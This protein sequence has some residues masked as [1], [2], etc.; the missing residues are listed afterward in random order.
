MLESLQFQL[1]YPR[2]GN[3]LC[4]KLMTFCAKMMTCMY[5]KGRTCTTTYMTS[6]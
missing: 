5:Y 6:R 2:A 4:M 3:D 1:L